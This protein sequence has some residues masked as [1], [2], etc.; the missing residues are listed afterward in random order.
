MAVPASQTWQ[1][2]RPRRNTGSPVSGGESEYEDAMSHDEQGGMTRVASMQSSVSWQDD[3][4]LLGTPTGGPSPVSIGDDGDTPNPLFEKQAVEDVGSGIGIA[5][6]DALQ[7]GSS[8]ADSAAASE[9]AES[10]KAARLQKLLDLDMDTIEPEPE[11]DMGLEAEPLSAAAVDVDG[12]DPH[13]LHL[14]VVPWLDE[15][16]PD[17]EIASGLWELDCFALVLD[18][19]SSAVFRL[20]FDPEVVM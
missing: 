5:L 3:E 14:R 1:P 10:A 7:D 9:S 19:E 4:P 15:L 8:I 16:P 6:A 13:P 11:V 2:R 20:S 12:A 17:G 18:C